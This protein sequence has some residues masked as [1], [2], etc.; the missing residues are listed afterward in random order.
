[1]VV[2]RQIKLPPIPFEQNVGPEA[3]Y[4][5]MEKKLEEDQCFTIDHSAKCRQSIRIIEWFFIAP[6]SKK[7]E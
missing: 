6:A 2:D 5:G 4:D 1:M 7:H 3:L